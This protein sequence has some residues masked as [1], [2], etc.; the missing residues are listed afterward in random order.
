[1]RITV[2]GSGYVGLVLGACLSENGNTVASVDKDTNKVATLAA[3]KM[4]I[5]E[6]GLEEIV[7]R[8]VAEERLSFT[9][10]LA[11]SVNT[12]EIVF[13]AVGTPSGEDGSADLQFVLDVARDIG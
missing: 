8:N 2:V 9:T 12:S 5:Y 13:I 3:G 10:D 1:M 4:T 11:G 7:R 6:P